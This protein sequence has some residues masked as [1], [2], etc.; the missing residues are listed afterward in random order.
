MTI[1]KLGY[2][3]Q[4]SPVAALK[5]IELELDTSLLLVESCSQG[6]HGS[7]MSDTEGYWSL[8]SEE[9]PQIENVHLFSLPTTCG[10]VLLSIIQHNIY[11][12]TNQYNVAIVLEDC[13]M[14]LTLTLSIAVNP[15]FID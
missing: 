13:N 12:N 8:A 14:A 2:S 5:P 15:S 4:P 3:E 6:P 11:K 1:F 7:H 9:F 10:R